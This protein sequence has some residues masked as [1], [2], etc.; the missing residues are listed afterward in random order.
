MAYVVI[1]FM[2]YPKP[3]SIYLRGTITPNPKSFR[4]YPRSSVDRGFRECAGEA[5][6]MWL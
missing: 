1:L 4:S 3:Y 5:S 2:I 6:R